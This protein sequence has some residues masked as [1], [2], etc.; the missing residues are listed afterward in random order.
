MIIEPTPDPTPIVGETKYTF[1][2][3]R[4]RKHRFA[5]LKIHKNG[6][7]LML[8]ETITE[9]GM[10]RYKK[11]AAAIFLKALEMGIPG[12]MF[13]RF[14]YDY[15]GIVMTYKGRPFCS[16]LD[17]EAYRRDNPVVAPAEVS[18]IIKPDLKTVVDM[19]RQELHLGPQV[20][21]Q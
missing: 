1:E 18:M 19:A 10:K 13:G 6:M 21:L 9:D 4:K 15:D 11:V 2:T 16:Y 12:T 14:E 17:R 8:P 7:L 20:T 5:R 3:E